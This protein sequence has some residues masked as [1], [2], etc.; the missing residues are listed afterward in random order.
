MR[1]QI[2]FL[3]LIGLTP[4]LFSQP[5]L[6]YNGQIYTSDTNNLN[7]SYFVVNNG[8]I[9]ETGDAISAERI[10]EFQKSE[11]LMGKTIIPGFI[12]S[13]IHFIDGALG[14]NQVNLVD[15]KDSV[16]LKQRILETLG[17]S[18]DGVYVA[19]DLSSYALLGVS[20]PLKYLDYISPEFP[21][22]IFLKSGHAAIANSAGMNILGFNEKTKIADGHLG[23][24]ET[25]KLNGWLMEAAAMEALK[26]I[27]EEYKYKTLENAILRGQ[28]LA[29]SYGITTI[30]DNTF[31][32]YNMKI[33]Q[34]MQR[35]G[36]LKLRIWT[37]SYGR[38]PQTTNLM[39]PMGLKKL[40]FIGP[41]NDFNRVHYHLSKLFTDMSL[42]IPTEITGNI[43]P[44][45]EVYL[46]KN[47]I[48]NYLLLNPETTFAFH[49]QGKKGLHNIIDALTD[50]GS[51]NNN[52]RHVIDHAGYCT[53]KQLEQLHNLGVSVTILASQTF[54]YPS[55]IKEYSNNNVSLIEDDLLNVRKK[56][57]ILHGA[58]T[59]DFPYGMDTS[60][61]QYPSNDGLNP[62]SNMAINITGMFPDGSEINGFANKTISVSEAIQSYTTNGAFVLGEDNFLGKISKGY[63]ADFIILNQKIPFT[64]P[65]ELYNME[66]LQTYIG[67]EKVY[68]RFN[69]LEPFQVDEAITPYDYTVS[70]LF[71]YDPTVGFIFGA[72]G[73][74]FPLK[75]P[76]NYGNI[77]IMAS[78]NGNFNIQGVF[79][80]FELFKNIEFKLPVTASNFVQYYYGESD[81]TNSSNYKVLFSDRI[82]IRPE[83]TLSL[84][85]GFQTSL[86]G[87][88]RYLNKTNLKDK[89]GNQLI[90]RLMPNETSLGVG[91]GLSY[92]TRDNPISTK[93]GFYG[94]AQYVNVSGIGQTNNINSNLIMVDFRYFNYIYNSKFVLATRFSAGALFG[95]SGY[96][97][98]YTLGGAERLRG[99]YTNRFRGDLFYSAQ[100]EFRFPLYKK[101][102]GVC[103]IDEGDISEKSLD[104]TLVTFG[105]GVRFSINS[106]VVLRLDYGIAKDQNGVFFTFGEAF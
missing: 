30:G 9:I 27:G 44:G 22:I 83:F 5:M 58:L 34:S 3:F 40:G 99:Y 52:R 4:K 102:S 66:V 48:E 77:Q 21:V 59:S 13:H 56:I 38:I 75:I 79:K 94:A 90:E 50:L 23:L 96:M 47:E 68:D 20:N 97:F 14:L 61:V 29:L 81:T 17:S 1:Y 84:S 103:F 18:S 39:G 6:Y 7:I 10:A 62:L 82:L 57:K 24:D 37:R 73:F 72:A 74:V 53:E 106:N 41:Q 64:N 104:K 80:R 35:E 86:F 105:G 60:F 100:A 88:F 8:V 15:V 91:M 67:G 42:S 45:G 49:V 70:P 51:R 11:N 12:D 95:N 19:R 55:L 28:E 69:P 65:M 92:D 2:A 89:Q 16:T 63:A 78:S 26:N 36:K 71:G 54:D 46:S 101:F 87:D 25:D 32:P 93:L 85:D 43:E 98:R 76:S 33:Y 31:S